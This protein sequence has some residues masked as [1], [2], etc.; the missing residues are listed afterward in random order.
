MITLKT[1]PGDS[2]MKAVMRTSDSSL[3]TSPKKPTFT[4]FLF[5]TLLP[6][7]NSSLFLF[8]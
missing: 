2:S 8:L 1:S 6:L 7:G 4:E 5:P 3:H